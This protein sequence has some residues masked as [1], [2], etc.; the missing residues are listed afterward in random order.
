VAVAVLVLLV[1]GTIGLYAWALTHWF[2][3]VQATGPAED[4]AIFR[5]LNV[6]IVG[7]DFYKV[8]HDTGLAVADLT[9]AARTRVR[10]GITAQSGT[11]ADRILAAL[12]DRR[13]PICPPVGG[14]TDSA[15]TTSSSAT[16]GSG[17]RAGST[18]RSA[19]RTPATTSAPVTGGTTPT[20]S[21]QTTQSS[22]PGVDCREVK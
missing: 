9:P 12:R 8:D 1:A 2:V 21:A 13:L 7:F 5:G 15:A 20:T 4:V 11:D 3:G 22:E 16:P 18:T 14:A 17:V 10:G 19:T 6:S